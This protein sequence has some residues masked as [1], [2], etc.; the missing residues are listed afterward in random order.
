MTL[1]S[2]YCYRIFDRLY[3][4][5]P[6]THDEAR[7]F[8]TAEL[9]RSRQVSLSAI[10]TWAIPTGICASKFEHS[11]GAAYLSKIVGR[12]AGF[13][14]IARDLYL[15]VLAHDLA[16]PPFS[17]ASEYFQIEL[18]GVNHEQAIESLLAD[19]EFA[20]IA[21]SQGGHLEF[22]GKLITGTSPPFS[23][24]VNGTID[25]DNLDN[26]LRYGLSMGL[27]EQLYDP[28][29][30]AHAF[31]W[32]NGTIVLESPHPRDLSGWEECRRQV[33]RYVYSTANLGPGMMLYRALDFAA[34]EDELTPAYFQMTDAAAFEYLSQRCNPRT[35]YL[36]ERVRR[37]QWYERVFSLAT[38]DPS[39]T[40]RALCSNSTLGG[41]VA[42]RIASGLK[43]PAEQVTVYMGKDKGFK[44]IHLPIV[45]ET[46]NL[47]HTPNQPLTWMIQVYLHPDH[48]HQVNDV[49][50]LMGAVIRGE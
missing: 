1:N 35:C 16:T 31:A 7:L 41:V 27:C 34:R 40:I 38:P 8:E 44:H 49:T 47:S 25:L 6:V 26:S 3:G 4:E 43:L 10:P 23:D 19:S 20:E 30:L 21:E 37:W 9:A 18:L 13:E 28:M 39:P 2:G 33:Y 46:G 50:E 42:D 15:A 24:L 22:I 14:E 12:K 5:I 36:I 11:V 48:A 17:H 29:R 32:S 45:G